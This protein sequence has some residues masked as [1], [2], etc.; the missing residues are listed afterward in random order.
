MLARLVRS[1][2]ASFGITLL[3]ALFLIVGGWRWIGPVPGPPIGGAL[4]GFTLVQSL[5]ASAGQAASVSVPL[6]QSDGSL[7]RVVVDGNLHFAHT[8]ESLSGDLL[9]TGGAFGRP[10]L[11]LG[12]ATPRLLGTDGSRAVLTSGAVDG[13]VLQVRLD[14]DPLVERYMISPSEAARALTG[15][16]T[17]ELWRRTPPVRGP[18]AGAP[19]WLAGLLLMSLGAATG[20]VG[21][22]IRRDARSAVLR[23][24]EQ[25][26]G[27]IAALR[28][29]IDPEDLGAA[30]LLSGLDRAGSEAR[31]LAQGIERRS[32]LL[33]ELGPETP[34]EEVQALRE[35]I[36]GAGRALEAIDQSVAEAAAHV[37]A[38]EASAAARDVEEGVTASL[39]ARAAL[40]RQVESLREADAEMDRIEGRVPRSEGPN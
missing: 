17:V 32:V 3:G 18:A 23:L 35:A 14:T 10:L 40:A 30:S 27:R 19:L 39:S 31:S 24:L 2:L 28:K 15:E 20:V 9:A 26:E 6:G 34:V 36:G 13:E 5:P 37:R 1:R 11:R 29:A 4:G 22:R 25:I 12:K 8:D 16:V 21:M 38:R 7:W 33:Q